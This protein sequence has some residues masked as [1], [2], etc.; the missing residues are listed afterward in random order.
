M[1]DRVV[2][3]LGRG[4]AVQ[5]RPVPGPHTLR[6]ARSQGAWRSLVRQ[7]LSEGSD[8]VEAV[9]VPVAGHHGII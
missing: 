3:L 7:V 4:H 9:V 6:A 1:P 5:L 8:A 2:A